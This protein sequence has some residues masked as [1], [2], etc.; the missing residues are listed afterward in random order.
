[1]S[2]AHNIAD[3]VS[4]LKNYRSDAF[5][6][7]KVPNFKIVSQSLDLL[8]K[9]GFISWYELNTETK[10]LDVCINLDKDGVNPMKYL[11][12][13]SKPSRKIRAK[14]SDIEILVKKSPFRLIVLS[15]SKGLM[16]AVDAI[17]ANVGGE[18]LFIV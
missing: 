12:S 4:R 10:M 3:L 9:N 14:V 16:S 8:V 13:I 5:S 17:K 15:T 2:C 7:C 11:H 6:L 18:V 1:M